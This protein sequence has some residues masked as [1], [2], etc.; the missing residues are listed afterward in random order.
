MKNEFTTIELEQDAR[1]VA[2]VW[3]A[4]P[5]VR[6]A[7]NGTMW[8]ELRTAFRRIEDDPAVRV[9][10]LS[11]RGE[12]FCSGGDLKYQG[13]QRDAPRDERVKEA[14]KLAHL[15]R[16]MDELSKPLIARVNGS[17]FAGGMSLVCV[18]DVAIGT[19]AGRFAITEARLGMVPGMISPY[20]TRRVGI[21]RARRL[22]LSA[23]Q[24]GGEDAV[25][26]GLLHETVAPE[27]LDAAVEEEVRLFLSCAPQAQATIKKLLAYVSTHGQDDNFG[28]AV[29]RVADMWDSPEA[30]EGI[31]SFF[32]KRKPHWNKG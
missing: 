27:A 32:E 19:T 8:E 9:V 31:A 18:A 26:F 5:Q 2:T 6:N 12:T 17:V 25:R 14:H 23:R 11:G 16:E 15:L 13:A 3:L 24:F 10:V 21:S 22:F 28:Y 20:V 4:R 1:G 30:Q 29:E 7:M